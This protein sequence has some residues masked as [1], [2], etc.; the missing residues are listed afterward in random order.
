MANDKKLKTKD[1]DDSDSGSDGEE[2]LEVNGN[3]A[4][5]LMSNVREELEKCLFNEN[6][7]INNSAK[8]LILKLFRVSEKAVQELC[9]K[10]IKLEKDN[11]NL[12]TEMKSKKGR[13]NVPGQT[14]AQVV[15]NRTVSGAQER[16]KEV[17]RRQDHKII[18]KPRDTDKFKDSENVKALLL[19]ELKD[20]TERLKVK[21]IIKLKDKSVLLNLDSENDV[22]LVEEG[23][24]ESL[25][26]VRPGKIAPRII[27]FN[28]PK[29]LPEDEMMTQL[30]IKNCVGIG[31]REELVS[32][33]KTLFRLKA[34]QGPNAKD[35]N[36]NHMVLSV[37]GRIY[38]AIIGV[39]RIFIGFNSFRVQEFISLTRCYKCQGFGHT[40]SVCRREKVVCSFCSG[41][42]HSFKDCPNKAK[43]PCCVN[44]KMRK[45][46]TEHEAGVKTCPEYVKNLD[47]YKRKINY[48]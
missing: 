11:K 10:N 13:E 37:S 14:Y 24:G 39:G 36:R 19:Q 26:T 34:K 5:N 7:K 43:T 18:I 20:V 8:Q 40:S 29:D 28:V 45:L 46:N 41:E 3:N 9:V 44:C 16:V 33:M 42:D 23:I 38:R 21:D 27:I 12:E 15:G 32:E 25:L 6:N 47:L 48:D 31:E 30:V 17:N 4:I 1:V 2:N 22:K 35:N